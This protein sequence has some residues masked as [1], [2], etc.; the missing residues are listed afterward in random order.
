M[1]TK[2]SVSSRDLIK[3]GSGGMLTDF[4][5]SAISK[6]VEP[7]RKGT[8]R[9]EI[10]G[11]TKKKYAAA[12]LLLTD[13]QT[14]YIAKRISVSQALLRKWKTEEVF[15]KQVLKN[16]QEFVE[17]HQR[18]FNEL[19]ESKNNRDCLLDD[20][21]FY[22]L[23]FFGPVLLGMEEGIK[24]RLKKEKSLEDRLKWLSWSLS[25]YTLIYERTPIASIEDFI[26]GKSILRIE[27]LCLM[28]LKSANR[29]HSVNSIQ[30]KQVQ[31]LLEGLVE[32]NLSKEGDEEA[33]FE[34]I[35]I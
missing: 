22:D 28:E 33:D 15:K 1:E 6:Y 31:V 8:P 10:I 26:L 35:F 32:L 21:R 18:K 29:T 11:F 16:E 9:G 34:A 2:T 13:L 17:Y 3:Q 4:I 25:Y 23:N 27:R 30:R 7:S 5:N 19:Y 14:E 20:Y 12:L 24:K